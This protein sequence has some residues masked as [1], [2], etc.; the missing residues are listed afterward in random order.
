MNH[1]FFHPLFL[2]SMLVKHTVVVHAGPN[3]AHMCLRSAVYL[4]VLLVLLSNTS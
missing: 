2:C 4:V 1:H 3:A